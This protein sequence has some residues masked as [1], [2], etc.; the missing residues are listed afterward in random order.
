[1]NI[2]QVI[3]G[4]G[5]IGFGIFLVVL[6][7]FIEP[8]AVALIYGLIL[9]VVGGFILFNTKEDKIEQIKK[10]KKEVK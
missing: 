3:T 2:S 10:R 4:I 9:S 7:F 8:R 5:L 1:M 6:S